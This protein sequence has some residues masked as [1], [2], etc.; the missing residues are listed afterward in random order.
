MNST[1]TLKR[2]VGL[3]TVVSTGAGLAL[4]SIS[5]VSLIEMSDHV[6]GNA[7][8]TALAVAGFICYLSSLC[9]AEL[10]GMFPSAAGIKLYI[11][12]AFGESAALVLASLY[13][14]TT[15]SIVGAETYILGNVLSFG[16]QGVP[17]LFWVI[18][19]LFS[20]CLINVRGVKL[21]GLFQDFVAYFK[22]FALIA[23]SWISL[24]KFNFPWSA[25]FQ[26]MLDKT[27]LDFFQAVGVGVFLFLGF[28]WVT[29]LAEEVEHPKFLSR[30]HERYFTPHWAIWSLF[31]LCALLSLFVA[32]T[33]IVKPFIYMGAFAE[34]LIYVA[35][36]ASLIKLRK[37]HPELQRPFKVRFLA[38]P[39]FVA[40]FFTVL[41]FGLLAENH[42]AAI[43][44][45]GLALIVL[46]YVKGVIPRMRSL[47][48]SDPSKPQVKRR[49]PVALS[50]NAAS[51]D[52]STEGQN[53]DDPNK[54]P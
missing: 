24:T 38:I 25:P 8:W 52:K 18:L 42:G 37:T 12:K 27:P 2:Q 7:G 13:I 19:F 47:A 17:V 9:F 5:Y 29:P 10:G 40:V 50:E 31:V 16:F 32:Y 48:S 15:L 45:G 22:F 21:T 43:A 1:Q 44:M 30:I 41:G 36:A 26:P 11:E 20:V 33:H 6:S 3:R 46:F 35:M 14:V 49:R 54:T 28:E 39:I 23:V 51:S 4:A 34:C 53:P